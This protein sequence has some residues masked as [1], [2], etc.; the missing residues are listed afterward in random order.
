MSENELEYKLSALC[1]SRAVIII[2][3]A[4]AGAI[5]NSSEWG[6]QYGNAPEYVLDS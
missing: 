5:Y 2:V 4:L 6:S 1:P 3:S